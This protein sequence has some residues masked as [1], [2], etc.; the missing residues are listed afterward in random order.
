MKKI[1]GFCFLAAVMILCCGCG[2]FT[3]EEQCVYCHKTPT[4]EYITSN[5]TACYI[6]ESHAKTCA[7][8]NKEFDKELSHS[9]NMLDVELFVCDECRKEYY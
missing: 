9:T 8:C 7:I 3:S 5:G 2:G 1:R 4:K 6:C